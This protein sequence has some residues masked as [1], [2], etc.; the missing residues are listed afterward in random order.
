MF[1]YRKMLHTVILIIE[2]LIITRAETGNN[3]IKLEMAQ[4]N[5]FN[6]SNEWV[7][8]ARIV[9]VLGGQPQYLGYSYDNSTGQVNFQF[10]KV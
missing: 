5:L 1:W 3:Y 6:T 7:Q 2:V 10:L 8:K 4:P 9:P